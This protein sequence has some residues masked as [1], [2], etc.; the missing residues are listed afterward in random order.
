MAPLK[1]P[2][3]ARPNHCPQARSTKSCGKPRVLTCWSL[4]MEMPTDR[5]SWDE[6][7]QVSA[8]SSAS[9]PA[10]RACQSIR[11]DPAE[12]EPKAVQPCKHVQQKPCRNSVFVSN[13][14]IAGQPH[15]RLSACRYVSLG[16]SCAHVFLK[17]DRSSASRA[18]FCIGVAPYPSPRRRFGEGPSARPSTSSE[19]GGAQHAG[20]NGLDEVDMR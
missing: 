3:G 19:T 5:L 8:K 6:R 2:A 18:W 13:T 4:F 10:S 12:V 16:F 7:S 17:S 14:R 11:R 15:R 9:H 20:A 1:D